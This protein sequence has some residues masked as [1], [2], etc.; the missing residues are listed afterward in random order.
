VDIQLAD[1]RLFALEER[2]SLDEIRQR[3]MD[4][5]TTAFGSGI[6][7]LLQRPKPDDVT[8]VAT[9][10]RVE[11]FWHVS[12]RARYVY[13][14]SRDYAVP[15][16]ATDVRSVTLGG[17][18]YPVGPTAKGAGFVVP[19]LEHC[20]DEFFDELH[21]D[22]VAGTPIADGAALIVGPSTE[23]GDPASLGVNETVVVPPEHRASSVVR[24]L[25]AR[26][27]RPLQADAVHEE[28]LELE[29]IDLYYRPVFAYEFLWG[30]KDKRGVIEIDGLSGQVRQVASLR[31]QLTRIISRDA[32]FDIGADTIGLLVPGGSIAVK[33]AR[34]ALDKSY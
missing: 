34:V 19:V 29:R 3:A 22:G 9:Q 12:C 25:L 20:R 14:R 5:R 7:G 31:T 8:V 32:L 27:M 6:G 4:K 15:S 28:A 18:D 10:R 26:M 16:S 1:Q 2:L 33:V 11:P 21:I 13:D 17:V 24:Q 30:S 23:V